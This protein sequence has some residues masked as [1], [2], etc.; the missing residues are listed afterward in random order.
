MKLIDTHSHLYSSQFEQDRTAA[1]QA[2]IR[3]GVGTI[4]LPN[5]SSEY[6]KGMNSLCAEFPDNCFAMMGLHPCY[7][8]ED[9]EKELESI[10]ATLDSPPD[11]MDFV[12]VGEIGLDLYWEKKFKAEQSEAF[13]TQARIAKERG[14]PIVIHVRDAWEELF[15]LMD[16]VNDESLRG[17]FHCFT[18]GLKEAER[19][20]KSSGRQALH[21]AGRGCP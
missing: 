16:K 19:A 14:L 5:I 10:M 3:A 1:V 8:N 7:V 18:G 9:W 4:L 17:V 21:L 6:T 20:E 11:D 2:A 13:L 15:T 12:A